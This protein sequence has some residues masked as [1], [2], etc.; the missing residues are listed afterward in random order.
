MNE[1]KYQ[2][3]L[4]SRQ[5]RVS[6]WDDFEINNIIY[7]ARIPLEDAN[8]LIVLYDPSEELL[9]FN[10]PKLWFT[11]EPSWHHHFRHDPVGKKLVRQ[12][13]PDEHIFYNN[14]VAEYRIPHPTF[15][16]PMSTPRNPNPK[17]AA[18]ACVNNY[19]G[20]GWFFK[21]HIWLRNRMILQP[22]VELFGDPN[23]W[24]R[25]RAFPKIWKKGAPRNFCNK[26]SPGK[27]MFD[28]EYIYFLSKYKVAVCLENCS[29]PNYFTEK[30]VNAV[31]AGCIPIYH[32]HSSVRKSFLTSAKWVDPCDFGFS[33]QRTISHALNE[34]QE[35]Y[36]QKNDKWL[37]SP[38]LETTDDRT[39]IPRLHKIMEMKIKNKI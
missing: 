14:Q 1:G 8:C 36:R 24:Q 33:P 20:K 23:S 10:G 31:R 19:G 7:S 25:F 18:V 37:K 38:I 9:K 13:R 3:R 34:N 16:S 22:N 17:L 2:C 39:I 15:R 26:K 32:A 21:R 30:I 35:E 5:F 28:E 11:I 27:D 4:V 6:D 29:E 12:L